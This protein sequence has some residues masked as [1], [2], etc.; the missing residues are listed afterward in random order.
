MNTGERIKELRLQKGYTLAA[1]GALVG[2]GAS[3]VRKWETGY[4]EHMRADKIDKLAAALDT[5]PAYVM[6]W[7]DNPRPITKQWVQDTSAVKHPLERIGYITAEDPNE[8]KQIIEINPDEENP[9][10]RVKTEHDIREEEIE[11]LKI[12]RSLNFRDRIKLLYY[13]LDLQNENKGA[14]R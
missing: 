1:L 4:I 14:A 2:V 8:L 6:C 13:A 5:T 9:Y 3:T 7:T 12:Y 10:R 11:L